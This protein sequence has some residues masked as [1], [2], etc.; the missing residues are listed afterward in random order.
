[1]RNHYLYG[2]LFCYQC[3]CSSC[4]HLSWFHFLLFVVVVVAAV[5]VVKTAR[6]APC[7]RYIAAVLPRAS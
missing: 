3:C 2:F 5:V 6:T 1:M 7:K 4:C